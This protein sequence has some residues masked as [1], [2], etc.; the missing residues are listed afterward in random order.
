MPL[1]LVRHGESHANEQNRFAGRLNSPLTALGIRQ[2]EQAAE[3]VAALGVRF[4]EV[5]VSPLSRAQQ[6]ARIILDRLPNPPTDVLVLDELVERDFGV[7][8]GQNKSLMKK[9]IGL[10]R[11]TEYFHSH[12]G[13]APGGEAWTEM[14]QRAADYYHE[15]LLPASS[16]G[17]HV[18]VVAHK[19]VVEML[20]LVI[21]GTPPNEYR[22]LKI[23]NA[24]PLD[25]H[26]LRK[27]ASAPTAARLINDLG[28]VVEIRLPLLVLG[29]ALL[30]PAV[31]LVWDVAVPAPMITLIMAALLAVCSFFGMLRVDPRVLRGTMGSFWSLPP[32][33]MLRV[34]AGLALVWSGG[35]L[36]LVLTGLY[37]LLPPALIAPTLSLLWGGEYFSA[38]RHTVAASLTVPLAAIG[39]LLVQN[40]L[41]WGNHL[42]P[43]T[44]GTI[45]ASYL[46]VLLLAL[47]APSGAAQLLRH[48]NPIRAGALSTNWSWLGSL[49]LIL[50]AAFTT[51]ALTPPHSLDDIHAVRSLL[52][53]FAAVGALLAVQRLFTA[54]LLRR[55]LR[56]RRTSGI[57]RDIYITQ[58]TPN[59]FLWLSMATT[60]APA[61]SRHH[62][63]L[64]LSTLLAFFSFMF[65]DERIFVRAHN[66]Q[67]GAQPTNARPAYVH[68]QSE[69]RRSALIPAAPQ[70]PQ[71][72]SAM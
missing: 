11:Y 44:L 35:G 72:V 24:R 52:T 6:T 2:A 47:A 33:L 30:G 62:S 63:L 8:A 46:T 41:P 22:D 54:A 50:L 61:D 65:I 51:F 1:Y 23:P 3:R 36:P 67:L 27:A 38:V 18:L 55:S 13:Q 64:G 26:D 32:M 57:A 68:Q 53:G 40:L 12:T 60:L 58:S 70:D 15:V 45:M 21:A 66:R 29:A 34:P 56:R 43:G 49:T 19:Y 25:E 31:R 37:L 10:R 16:S 39:A 20:A 4:D 14:Y 28:E 17:R 9:S 69:R 7:F 59:V 42:A 5:H 48:R 71:P